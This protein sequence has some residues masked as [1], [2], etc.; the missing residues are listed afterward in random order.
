MCSFAKPLTSQYVESIVH[1]FSKWRTLQK[2]PRLE[3]P[4]LCEPFFT[5]AA[6]TFVLHQSTSDLGRFFSA[7]HPCY[8]NQTS[9]LE[10]QV[11]MYK[12]TEHSNLITRCR[13]GQERTHTLVN[14][15]MGKK[16]CSASVS[17][18]HP[19]KSSLSYPKVSSD[20]PPEASID[21][22]SAPLVILA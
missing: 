17:M 16:K 3:N 21:F 10:T 7:Q 5:V 18:L 20:F 6:V 12:S 4:G 8:S 13:R 11:H 15:L 1:C 9:M 2:N 22:P 14:T 19:N